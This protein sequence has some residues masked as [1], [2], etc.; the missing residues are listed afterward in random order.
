MASEEDE[1]AELSIRQKLK[2]LHDDS[3]EPGLLQELCT[4]KVSVQ[5]LSQTMSTLV[6]QEHHLWLDL[7]EM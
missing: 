3:S 1:E 2:E 6:L 5:D 7:A 4:T